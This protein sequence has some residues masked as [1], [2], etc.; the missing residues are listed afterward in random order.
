MVVVIIEDVYGERAINV[1]DCSS[2]SMSSLTVSYVDS[3]T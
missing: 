3:T 1:R 2:C